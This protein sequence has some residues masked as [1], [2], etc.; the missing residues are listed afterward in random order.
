MAVDYPDTGGG[1]RVRPRRGRVRRLERCG[2]RGNRARGAARGQRD[3]RPAAGPAAPART[4]TCG[5]T[6]AS[7]TAASRCWRCTRPPGGRTCA[8]RGTWPR[9]SSGCEGYENIPVRRPRAAAGRGPDRPAAAAPRPSAGRWPGP[10]TS[11]CSASRSAPPLTSTGCCCPPDDPRRRAPVIANPLND[12]EPL[13]RTMLL[14]GLLRVLVRNIGRG[15]PDVGLF[16]T[17]HGLPAAPNGPQHRS[18]SCGPTAARRC[19][20]WPPWRRRCPTSR[21]TSRRWSTGERELDGWWGPGGPA[22]WQDAIEAART[23]AARPAG[24]RSRSGPTR[25]RPGIPGAAPRCS[26]PGKARLGGPG[27]A[28]RVRG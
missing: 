27:V 15:F 12:D 19:T 6:T 16:E 10:A 9:R 8:T 25:R 4:A 2:L 18:R 26:S 24:S 22:G 11:R 17:G 7:M 13:L 1:H 20:S 5:P 21:C 28:G 14:P 3:Q 23:G